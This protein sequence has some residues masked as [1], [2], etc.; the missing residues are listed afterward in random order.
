MDPTKN[1]HLIETMQSCKYNKKGLRRFLH[2]WKQNNNEFMRY[3]KQ[4]YN[5]IT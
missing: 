5:N 2:I 4:Q 1:N 3:W